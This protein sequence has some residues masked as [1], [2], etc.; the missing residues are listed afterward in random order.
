[1]LRGGLLRADFPLMLTSPRRDASGPRSIPPLL[2]FTRE[3]PDHN[4]GWFYLMQA[5]FALNDCDKAIEAAERCL[6]ATEGDADVLALVWT[7]YSLLLWKQGRESESVKACYQGLAEFP[8]HPALHRL[9]VT[10]ALK[11]WYDASAHTIAHPEEGYIHQ[12][13]HYLITPTQLAKMVHEGGIEDLLVVSGVDIPKPRRGAHQAEIKRH[14]INHS[15]SS[16]KKRLQKKKKRKK[17][18]ASRRR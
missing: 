11:Q 2:K 12:G 15:A 1:M 17:A 14:V 7:T 6:T 3:H 10:Y 18:K 4:H 5:H 13:E 16:T 9:R 8:N